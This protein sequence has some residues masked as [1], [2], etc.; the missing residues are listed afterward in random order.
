MTTIILKTSKNGLLQLFKEIDYHSIVYQI[1]VFVKRG[2]KIA[3]R[4]SVRYNDYLPALLAYENSPE[5]YQN[6]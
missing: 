1:D 6:F 4:N 2:D 5:V 3:L